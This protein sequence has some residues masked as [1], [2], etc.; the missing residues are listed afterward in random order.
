MVYFK[1]KSIQEGK[2]KLENTIEIYEIV[3][4][5]VYG[6]IKPITTWLEG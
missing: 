3:Q 5:V 4:G 6:K 1:E 2:E